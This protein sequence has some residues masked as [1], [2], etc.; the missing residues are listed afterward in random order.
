METLKHLLSALHICP[1]FTGGCRCRCRCSFLKLQCLYQ[2]LWSDFSTSKDPSREGAP[3]QGLGKRYN[4]NKY[5]YIIYNTITSDT[6]RFGSIHSLDS[7]FF[8][9]K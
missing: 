3:C 6:S 5:N 8:N 2:G 9:K 1:T 7:P 4:I